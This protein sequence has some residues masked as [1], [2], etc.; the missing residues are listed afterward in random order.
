MMDGLAFFHAKVVACAGE[1]EVRA[2]IRM[3]IA[4]LIE[5]RNTTF[6]DLDLI[7]RTLPQ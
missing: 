1:C 4:L 2:A 5:G 6:L 7:V 3:A